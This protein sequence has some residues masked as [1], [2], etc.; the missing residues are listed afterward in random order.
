MARKASR[1]G[2]TH[3]V[4]IGRDAKTGRFLKVQ[5]A[6]RRKT[7]SV[8]TIKRGRAQPARKPAAKPARKRR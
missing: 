8:E 5:D 1:G 6:R 7:A 2:K 3:T 4:T